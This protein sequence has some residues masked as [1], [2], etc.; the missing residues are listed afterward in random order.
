MS[1]SINWIS[2]GNLEALRQ[3]G[4]KVIRGGIAVSTGYSKY[5]R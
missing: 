5:V 4:E 3:E 1:I 2:A